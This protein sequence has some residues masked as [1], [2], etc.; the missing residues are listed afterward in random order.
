MSWFLRHGSGALRVPCFG[1]KRWCPSAYL[2]VVVV[3]AGALFVVSRYNYLLFHSLVELTAIV[4]SGVFFA[5][6][7][8]MLRRSGHEFL[9]LLA[10]GFSASAVIDLVHALAYKGMGVFPSYTSNLPTQLW[11]LARYL[12][13]LVILGASIWLGRRLRR[14]WALP[15]ALGV[16]TASG[17]AFIFL[18]W[19]PTAYVEGSGLTHF[20]IISE[21]V[22]VVILVAALVIIGQKRSLLDRWTLSW[23][24]GAVV[25]T[26][27]AEV[28]FT[29]Y[30]SVYGT[31]NALGHICKFLAYT[32][33]LR[34]VVRNM[35]E[36]PMQVFGAIVPVCARCKAVRVA[37]NEWV[38]VEDYLSEQAGKPVSHGLCPRCYQE[39]LRESGLSE[40]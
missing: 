18:G 9:F 11:I 26:I 10:T 1:G 20:K 29:R 27:A 6:A 16:I 23:L 4:T 30:V 31:F 34:L 3:L 37:D 39:M 40:D 35:L 13:A 19:F 21:Y 2:V 38:M 28:C 15:L 36:R 7:V 12:E 24:G 32:T 33:M 17:I 8:V 5:V 14:W 25:L 22:I